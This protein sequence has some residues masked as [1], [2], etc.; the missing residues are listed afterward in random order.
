MPNGQGSSRVL[1]RIVLLVVLVLLGTS[2]SAAHSDNR[3]SAHREAGPIYV[4][5][6]TSSWKPRGRV[7]YDITGSIRSKL[8]EAGLDIV[9]TSEEPRDLV[10]SVAY[11]ESQG[12]QYAINSYGTIITCTF[13]LSYDGRHPIFD[14]TI[15]ESSDPSHSGTPPYLDALERFQ[16][17]PYYYFLGPIVAARLQSQ[18]DPVDGLVAGL[19]QEA[20][21]GIEQASSSSSSENKYQ[22]TMQPS[23]MVYAS[24]ASIRAVEELGRLHHTEAIPVLLTLLEYPDP[25]VQ[26]KTREVLKALEARTSPAPRPSHGSPS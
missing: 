19:R 9:R 23:D 5:V 4:D 6:Q 17:N 25:R 10:L 13:S 7:L 16:T 1:N 8:S 22:H 14:M 15:E 2:L 26:A 11:Q 18:L 12:E 3:T 21:K 24:E 20:I